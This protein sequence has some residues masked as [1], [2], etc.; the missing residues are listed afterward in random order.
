MSELTAEIERQAASW[1][2][3][4]ADPSTGDADRAQFRAWLAVSP[5]HRE[6]ADEAAALWRGMQPLVDDP[7]LRAERRRARR[8]RLVND[9]DRPPLSWRRPVLAGMVVAG[10]AAIAVLVLS[11][12][13]FRQQSPA[14]VRYATSNDQ[15]LT[16]TL[17]DGTVATLDLDTEIAV[18]LGPSW[19]RVQ[20]LKG[21][22]F[23]AVKPDKSRPL[24]AFTDLL[25][26]RA[27]GTEFSVRALADHTRVVLAEGGVQVTDLA[28]PATRVALRPGQEAGLTRGQRRLL[29]RPVDPAAALAWRQGRVVFRATP[30]A[31]AIAEMNRYA[32]RPLLF[33]ARRIGTQEINGT[34]DA[35]DTRKFAQTLTRILPLVLREQPDGSLV[36]DRRP[37]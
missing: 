27:T 33:D 16:A 22:V 36:L 25:S 14:A 5:A 23:L 31:E 1:V 20:V 13:M 19:R 18:T 24:D 12:G 34:F 26:V 17:A 9:R 15:R 2:A 37:N 3:L 8:W 7:S 6:A 29:V 30:F 35:G 21:E 10:F 28:S 11:P 32:S 4:L